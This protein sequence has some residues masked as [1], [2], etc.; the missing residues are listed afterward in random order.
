MAETT[1]RGSDQGNGS[2]FSY[3]DLEQRVRPDHPLRVIREIANAS[4]EAL[5]EDFAALYSPFGRESIP[6]ERLVRALLLQ[7]FYSIR[8]ERQLVE[9]IEYDLLFRWFVG[10][11]IDE[12]VWDATTFTKNRDR[13]LAGDVATK[14]L[15]AVVSQS[16]VK[17]LLSS[18][19]F[20]VDGTLIE[21]WAS[22]KSF[23]PR[24]G[25]GEP[26]GP[27]RNGERDFH[28]ERRTNDT[29]ASTTDPDARLSRKGRGKEAKLSF[30]G[31]ALMENRNGLIVGA[32]A[33]R[34]SGHA[35]RLAALALIEPHAERPHPITLGGDKNY[36]TN[37]FV[38]ELR[39]RA[40]T[41][42]VAQNDTNRR[43][44]IDGRTTRHPGYA[45]SMRIRKRI[46]EAFGW[47]KTVA[48]MR[49]MRHRGLPKVDWQFTLAMTAY[50]LVRL[51]KL[52]VDA[53]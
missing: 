23:K 6:P 27:G 53:A 17:R 43:S 21:A 9:R 45:V 51:P 1:M 5:S 3:V 2:L 47:A 50:N 32:V 19:H 28:G 11:G 4:L 36:D 37:D 40:V 14:F 22:P 35:E 10:L 48:G 18:E 13:L 15:S 25:S 38:A 8:S 39:E 12:V 44:A 31:H 52:L 24:D 7:A 34:A 30:M 20:S 16:R 46:E 26:P 42:H 33:T 41:P 29:H 49:K